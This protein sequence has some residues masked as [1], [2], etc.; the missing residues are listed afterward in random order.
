MNWT[1]GKVIQKSLIQAKLDLFL[2]NFQRQRQPGV[3]HV[4]TESLFLQV[5]EFSQGINITGQKL[6]LCCLTSIFFHLLYY[7]PNWYK[8]GR[9]P[10]ENHTHHKTGTH[11][12]NP[13]LSLKGKEIALQCKQTE[14]L[15]LRWAGWAE[16]PYRSALSL[17]GGGLL[18]KRGHSVL[19]PWVCTEFS[20][21]F[22]LGTPEEGIVTKLKSC[23]EM[24]N[25]K[26]EGLFHICEFY[27]DHFWWPLHDSLS[28]HT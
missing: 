25:L 10:Y 24:N 1:H 9:K 17:E 19:K 14:N 28:P 13:S 22:I 8:Q 23:F 6:P 16:W 7:F 20:T 2:N 18:I 21:A 5:K 27:L 12:K 26:K 3:L 4:N 15:L 11:G